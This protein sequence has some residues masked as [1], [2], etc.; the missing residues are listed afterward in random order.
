MSTRSACF[1]NFSAISL[2]LITVYYLHYHSS[3]DLIGC[4][5]VGSS[6]KRR[7][8]RERERRHRRKF[9]PPSPP[10]LR[11]FK[12]YCGGVF[13]TTIKMHLFGQLQLM[14]VN[15]YDWLN[16]GDARWWT[17]AL[18][19]SPSVDGLVLMRTRRRVEYFSRQGKWH[20]V[21]EESS[22]VQLLM[23]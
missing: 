18:F 16:Y 5:R 15:D 9:S 17:M 11:G 4:N 23:E 3:I 19:F 14:T 22:V 2:V 6:K 7:S 12:A 20:R 13:E 8:S 1:R 21:A 10:T